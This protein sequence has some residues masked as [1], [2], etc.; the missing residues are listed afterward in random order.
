MTHNGFPSGTLDYS[1]TVGN[2]IKRLEFD[3]DAN[4]Y[5]DLVHIDGIDKELEAPKEEAD[6]QN[7]ESNNAE[8]SN[9]DEGKKKYVKMLLGGFIAMIYYL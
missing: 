6:M 3:Y 5:R 4:E 9:A 8:N 2:N 1:C 7:G